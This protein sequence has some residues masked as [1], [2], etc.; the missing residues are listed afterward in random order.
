MKSSK[1]LDKIIYDNIS[2]SLEIVQNINEYLKANLNDINL[3]KQSLKTIKSKMKSFEAVINYANDLSRFIA[4]GDYSG[5]NK[6]LHE[7]QNK[8][9]YS[10]HKIYLNIKPLLKNTKRIFTLSNSKTVYQVLKYFNEDK[11]PANVIIAESRPVLEGRILAKKLLKL[12]I[13]VTLIPDCDSANFIS[14]CDAVL[15]GAD[16]ILSN[17]DVVNKTGS[18]SIAIIAKYFNKPVYVLAS[19]KKLSKQKIFR[20]ELQNPKEV[21]R[22]EHPNLKIVS[23]YFEVIPR[24]LISKVITESNVY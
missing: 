2:G 13:E 10:F 4:A 20:Q 1:Y 18:I 12:G 11:N 21:W 15:L 14:N 3:I 6:F 24:N 8:S 9:D 5:L 16:K 7:F 23:Y 19:D 22:Y 17:G